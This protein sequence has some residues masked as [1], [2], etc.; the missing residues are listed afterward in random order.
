MPSRRTKDEGL[1]TE[2]GSGLVTVLAMTA[3]VTTLI[4]VVLALFVTQHRFIQRDVHRTEAIYRAEAAVYQALARLHTDPDWRPVGDSLAPL[5]YPVPDGGG[6]Q[7]RRVSPAPRVWARPLGGFWQLRA[8][9]QVGTATASVRTRFGEHPTRHFDQ[10]LVLGDTLSALTLTAEARL[11]GGIRMGSQG[12]RTAPLRGRP[13]R[14]SFQGGATQ[15]REDPLPRF[16]PRLFDETMDRLDAYLTEARRVAGDPP[17]GSSDEEG[18]LFPWPAALDP[19]V[20]DIAAEGLFTD[21]LQVL[22]GRGIVALTPEDSLL[23]RRPIFLLVNGDLTLSGPLRFALGS[24]LAVTGD[25]TFGPEVAGQEFLV[26]ARTI[27]A[28]GANLS[29]QLLARDGVRLDG[30]TRLAYPSVVYVEGKDGAQ[31]NAGR[32]HTGSLDTEVGEEGA[33]SDAPQDLVVASASV[34][35]T[36]LYPALGGV[37][38]GQGASVQLEEEARIRGAVYANTRTETSAR[39]DGTLLTRQLFFYEAPAT[40]INWLRA[41][42][43]NRPARPESFVLPIGF[44]TPPSLRRTDEPRYEVVSWQEQISTA[45]TDV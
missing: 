11:I 36:L 6:D 31:A 44:D 33:R 9:A 7:E 26:Y 12:V 4:G 16:S 21:S 34:D 15:V 30:S 35:G 19:N 17:P 43:L 1:R 28:S 18:T 3:V 39:L 42:T 24:T 5:P 2:T 27:A 20:S 37:A 14:G 23:L 32:T 10:A 41:G 8:D 38:A 40:Y 25:L 45:R 22:V 29:G 13:F